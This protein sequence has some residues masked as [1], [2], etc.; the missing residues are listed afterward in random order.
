MWNS[1]K[2]LVR[3]GALDNLS[4]EFHTGEPFSN[5]VIDN[6]FKADVIE[7]IE[8]EFPDFDSGA[9]HE[10]NNPLEIKKTCN[11][12]NNFEPYTYTIFSILNDNKTANFFQSV[13]NLDFELYA[14]P[15]LNGGGQHIHKA[16]GK[17]NTHLDYSLHPKLTLERRINLII[18]VNRNWV[19]NWKGALGFWD[20][21]SSEKP[22]K[23]VK[24]ID[25]LY[26]RAVIFDTSQNSWHGL[27]DPVECPVHE[28]RKS[29]AIYYLSRPSS[30]VIDRSR[31]L[32]APTESQINSPEIRE[33]I[34]LRSGVE[35]SKTVYDDK[36]S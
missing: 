4:D 27:P 34:K 10:Y 17:L 6:F 21:K 8:N 12:W 25:C 33:L 28:A 24:S 11:N 36:E 14:D 23:L 1:I 26:N 16:G 29:L 18:Y 3:P 30:T 31:A 32:F 2:D 7:A 22:G 15:G 5:V 9:W 20:N 19:T 13:L 35:T